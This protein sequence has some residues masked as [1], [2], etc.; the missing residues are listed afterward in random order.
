MNFEPD[1]IARYGISSALCEL[2]HKQLG[3]FYRQQ[4][5]LGSMSTM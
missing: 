3:I 2:D 5:K 1:F 4:L